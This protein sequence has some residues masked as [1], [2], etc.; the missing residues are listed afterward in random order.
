MRLNTNAWGEGLIPDLPAS[1]GAEQTPILTHSIEG[2]TSV[3]VSR[4]FAITELSLDLGPVY[5]ERAE[6]GI[7]FT[8]AGAHPGKHFF[9]RETNSSACETNSREPETNS[10]PP[11]TNSRIGAKHFENTG[12]GG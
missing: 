11:E 10:K 7:H 4:Q 1:S 8:C 6:Y 5:D 3:L 12:C 9:A 2:T